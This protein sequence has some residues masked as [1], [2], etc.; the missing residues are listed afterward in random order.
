MS[1]P[2]GVEAAP[3]VD[4]GPGG[5]RKWPKDLS[6]LRFGRLRVQDVH[7]LCSCGTGTQLVWRCLCDCGAVTLVHAGNLK[8]GRTRSC[9][10]FR[11]EESAR[12]NQARSAVAPGQRYGRL[13]A[14]D[15]A[16][17]VSVGKSGKM[18]R[19]MRCLCDCGRLAMVR[20]GNLQS[21][22]S[23]S[24]GC[25]GVANGALARSAAT[26]ALG[27]WLAANPFGLADVDRGPVCG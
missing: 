7:G 6:G 4:A 15:W 25:A 24:C 16:G 13:L 22:N 27:G 8:R 5:R 26:R 10:C 23:R 9:G 14:Q 1:A 12:R 21:G 2:A 11:N 3:G 18:H 19:V 20:A 17:L